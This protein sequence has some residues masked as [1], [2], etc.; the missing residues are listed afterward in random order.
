MFDVYRGF[1]GHGFCGDPANGDHDCP[2]PMFDWHRF[3][4]EVWDWWWYPFDY[5]TATPD[6]AVAARPYSL[7][8][9]D[10]DTPLKE[11]YWGALL[12]D[13]Q[14]RVTTGIHGATGSPQT[15]GLPDGSRVYAVAN[16]ELVAARF[17]AETGQPSLA[18]MVVR[19]E[20]YHKLD[21]RPAAAGTATTLPVFANRIDYD[22]SAQHRLH[23]V[24]AP[25]PAHGNELRRRGR[26]EPRL[27]QSR[28]RAQDGG[29][30]GHRVQGH[31][32]GA[33]DIERQ[34]ERRGALR[35]GH[36]ADAGGRLGRRRHRPDHL[37]GH[38]ERRQ[39]RHRSAGRGHHAHP[40]PAGRLPW[41]TRASSRDHLATHKGVRVEIFSNDVISTEFMLTDT[42]TAGTCWMPLV[43]TGVPA[44]RYPSEWSHDPTDA[45]L[46]GCRQ[47]STRR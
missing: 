28:D 20:V 40:H 32:G 39:P 11:Y 17:P 15:F 13:M 38:A 25:G 44:V 12:A 6:T 18:F 19:H 1:H 23:A 27:A 3:A 8:T 5:A 34:V 4:R 24:H 31:G 9:R 10:G 30:P 7:A 45:Q 29:P 26:P 14:G 2:G 47:V 46:P 21:V 41:P 42:T 22:H 35:G 37:P 36:A 43:G 33:G 16:G